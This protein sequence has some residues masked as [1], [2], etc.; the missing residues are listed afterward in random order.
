MHQAPSLAL[1]THFPRSRPVT[2]QTTK[3]AREMYRRLLKKIFKKIVS[4]LKPQGLK[5]IEEDITTES[6]VSQTSIQ[7]I[8]LPPELLSMI[9]SHLDPVN[10]VCLQVTCQ[11][12][13]EFVIV[14]RVA[15]ENDRCRKW[16]LTRFLEDDMDKYPS[17][18]VCPFCK[19]VR[20]TKF[21]RV[22]DHETVHVG[23][24]RGCEDN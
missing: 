4:Y 1:N 19:S 5:K 18:I 16:A 17:K 15:L 21:F 12:F 13:R 11:F 24:T 8:S 7:L 20:P 14:D 23:W 2:T 3:T 22:F 6:D 10:Q 9:I